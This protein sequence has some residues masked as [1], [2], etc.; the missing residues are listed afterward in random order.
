MWPTICYFKPILFHQIKGHFS[1]Q[2]SWARKTQPTGCGLCSDFGPQCQVTTRGSTP[3]RVSTPQCIG[4]QCH[5]VPKVHV[6]TISEKPFCLA[7]GW[8]IGSSR[9][10]PW[11]N[12]LQLPSLRQYDIRS[13]DLVCYLLFGVIIAPFQARMISRQKSSRMQP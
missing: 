10:D 11:L 12:M 9:K 8:S 7:V 2:E 4:I 1:F 3:A 6:A 5:L 13:T